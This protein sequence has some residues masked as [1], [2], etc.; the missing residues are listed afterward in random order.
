MDRKA[1]DGF[2]KAIES[3]KKYRRAD[4]IDENGK[5]LLE[6]LYTDLLPDDHIL[7]K[8][9]QDNTVFLIG[10]KG[11]GKST[12]F[13]RL[14]QE[15]RKQNE[16][17]PCYL[18][19]KTLFES[20]KSENILDYKHIIDNKEFLEKYLVKRN[21]LRT[22][23]VKLIQ[24]ID[25]KIDNIIKKLLTG[26]KS[27][28]VIK[29]LGKILNTLE[30]NDALSQIEMPILQSINVKD[31]VQ[32]SSSNTILSSDGIKVSAS[33]C[34]P[35]VNASGE[36]SDSSSENHT[37]SVNTEKVYS[38][39]LLKVLRISEF[40]LKIKGELSKLGIKHLVILLDDFSEIPDEDLRT[41]VDVILA[42]LNNWSEEFIKFKVAAYPGRV[43]YGSIDPGKVDVINLDFY[44]LYSEFERDKMEER[45]I[46]FTRRL[47]E[48]RINH[49]CASNISTFF[50]VKTKYKMPDYYRLLF[51]VSMNVPRV[52]GY[53]LSFCYDSKTLY[54]KLITKTDIE[55]AAEK[56]Y[57]TKVYPFFTEMTYSIMSL[58]SKINYLQLKELLEGIVLKLLDVK[59]KIISD[60]Y[61][62]GLY[63]PSAPYSSHFYIQEA[64][65][66]YLE[67]L[68]LNFFVSKYTELSDKDGKKVS[69]YCLN[70]G[71]CQKYNLLWGKPDGGKFSKYFTQ[72]PFNM[73][74]VIN[75]FLMRTQVIYCSKC[76]KKF[77]QDQLPYLEFAHFKCNSCGGLVV[78]RSMLSTSMRDKL[79]KIQESDLLP[80][81]ETK[82]LLYL[83]KQNH[84][85]L[86]RDIAE[87][88]DMS[89]QSV[90]KICKR[91]ESEYSYIKRLRQG[92]DK[93]SYI[94]TQKAK[95]LYS[96]CG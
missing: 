50:D 72:R 92:T 20:S 29:D 64:Y 83:S 10:R 40:L 80:Q 84:A 74:V 36:L 95:S 63:L 23:L 12:I 49:Y 61:T 56:Y 14:E 26:M 71:L 21:F 45:A 19:V 55:K 66:K 34:S 48:K 85:L 17:I 13:L 25:N 59:K 54:D 81:A 15:Y 73:S 5:S 2:V 91:M 1:K 65:S 62:G 75:E 53:I 94:A 78:K 46:D 89:S 31:G 86:A 96:Q 33:L 28:Q 87:E 52:L 22:V 38:E 77:T 35:G 51:S 39:I 88:L 32:N 57:E 18:D 69:V 93:Y 41:F 76:G 58:N 3:L 4:L 90:A 6:D 24:E 30:N 44:N 68:E 60:D 70:Y 8:C 43:Y 42:P 9:L 79:H 67:T 47:L 7:K 16:Y 37:Q 82:V 27:P 11:T